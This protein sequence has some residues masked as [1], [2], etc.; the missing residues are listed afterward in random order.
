MLAP[1]E[2]SVPTAYGKIS[3]LDSKNEGPAVLLIHGNSACKEVFR[4]Q[5]NDVLS[6]GYR[7]IAM[8]LPGHGRSEDARNPEEIYSL[9]GYAAAAEDLL[10]KLKIKK[11]TVVGW[12]LGGHIALEMLKTSIV[13]NGALITG[14]PP[15]PMTAEG[16]G[17][18]FLPFPCIKLLSQEKFSREEAELFI[19]QGGFN[20]KEDTF[21]VDA[22]IR[23]HGVAR[24]C[25][26]NSM[27]K[28]I[29]GDQKRTVE[30][31]DK[32]VAIVAATNDTGI[33]NKYIEEEVSKKS[34]WQ[35]KVH[36]VKGGHGMF[37]ENPNDFN[38]IMYDFLKDVNTEKKSK[39]TSVNFVIGCL[40]VLTIA[41]IAQKF[42][43]KK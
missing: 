11:V 30:E 9:P 38:P 14:T 2:Y 13:V 7:L 12:S 1:V 21:M 23:T 17:K 8:D 34:L 28:G 35:K 29:G 39:K 40:V 31:S 6:K 16:F 5:F 20:P 19:S 3:I 37:W 26:I 33:N 15:I 22:A 24:A 43:I 4:K 27:T 42:F 32:P 10:E 18:G 41:F 36:Y 25:A